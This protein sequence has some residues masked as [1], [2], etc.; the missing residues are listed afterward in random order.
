MNKLNHITKAICNNK[1]ESKNRH[2]HITYSHEPMLWI[3]IR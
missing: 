2:K 1:Y 3:D